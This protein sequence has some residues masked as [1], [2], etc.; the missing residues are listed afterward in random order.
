[1]SAFELEDGVEQ[2]VAETRVLAPGEFVVFLSAPRCEFHYRV[3]VDF[4]G[5]FQLVDA[6][7]Q[8]RVRRMGNFGQFY[9]VHS[10][11]PPFELS[12][13]D[14]SKTS[15]ADDN[16]NRPFIQVSAQSG[17]LVLKYQV[18]DPADK[19]TDPGL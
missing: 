12:P 11:F 5:D 4:N 17:R 2:P 15:L 9:N 8:D 10:G 14:L 6:T 7:G 18:L 3:M 16:A 13:Q 1:M 19:P